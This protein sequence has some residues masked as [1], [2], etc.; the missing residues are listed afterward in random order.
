MIKKIVEKY[1]LYVYKPTYHFSTTY[2]IYNFPPTYLPDKVSLYLWRL[3]RTKSSQSIF[4]INY[5]A[6]NENL[7]QKTTIFTKIS[8]TQIECHTYTY[9]LCVLN[10]GWNIYVWKQIIWIFHFVCGFLNINLH[11][12][13]TFHF[14]YPNLFKFKR[15]T[16]GLP[17]SKYLIGFATHLNLSDDIYRFTVFIVSCLSLYHFRPQKFNFSPIMKK[18]FS[19]C[20]Y[21]TNHRK[22]NFFRAMS[23]CTWQL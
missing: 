2:V 5:F 19:W 10:F 18:Q 11:L 8:I 4:L 6:W 17:N 3:I 1:Y 21:V 22:F 12:Q 13:F 7:L 14:T 9:N 23:W 20:Y 16:K 15:R